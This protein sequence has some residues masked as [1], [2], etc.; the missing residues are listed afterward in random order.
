[1]LVATN[2]QVNEVL[3]AFKNIVF[4]CIIVTKKSVYA[5][6]QVNS[7]TEHV[8]KVHISVN[9]GIKRAANGNTVI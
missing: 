2:V 8:D 4:Q 6:V 9:I 7:F 5:K 1:M 3:N